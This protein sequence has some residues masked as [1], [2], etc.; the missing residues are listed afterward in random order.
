MR[1]D[2]QCVSR[3]PGITGWRSREALTLSDGSIH[4]E[5]SSSDSDTERSKWTEIRGAESRLDSS[6]KMEKNYKLWSASV[7]G[8]W[9][10]AFREYMA[11]RE[12]LQ[13]LDHELWGKNGEGLLFQDARSFYVPWQKSKVA[14]L[15]GK[16][17]K[18]GIMH[19]L[20]KVKNGGVCHHLNSEVWPS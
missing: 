10:Q 13:L 9:F 1:R 20:G 2:Q 4:V 5:I 8:F 16:G 12:D 15:N 3:G 17:H 14:L 19:A 7:E 6:W 11:L 18:T